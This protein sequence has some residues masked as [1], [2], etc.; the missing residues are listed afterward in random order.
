M[1]FELKCRIC[2]KLDVSR[3]FLSVTPEEISQI[4]L[5]SSIKV[6]ESSIICSKCLKRLKNAIKFRNDC[7]KASKYFNGSSTCDQV[8]VA[9]ER[10][11][12]R[13]QCTKCPKIF[14]CLY[15]LKQHEIAAHTEIC[16]EELFYCDQ[17][18]F[19]S[20][21][22]NLMRAHQVNHHCDLE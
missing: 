21:T 16:P 12:K 2:L 9:N 7:I 10:K 17:C 20:K 4:F 18:E 11:S 6:D 14:S 3:N 1:S 22:K 15:Y 5:L 19:S 8:E 13:Y